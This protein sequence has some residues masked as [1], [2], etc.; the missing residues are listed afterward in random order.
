[1]RVKTRDVPMLN[2]LHPASTRIMSKPDISVASQAGE[3]NQVRTIAGHIL[4]QPGTVRTV[5]I[6]TQF[7]PVI[8]T[9]R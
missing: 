5:N 1:M 8:I 7:L 2:P 3:W 4:T 9:I 6:I